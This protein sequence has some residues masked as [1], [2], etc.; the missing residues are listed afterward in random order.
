[1]AFSE[2]IPKLY[3]INLPIPRGGFESFLDGWLIRDEKRRRTLLVETGPASA[4]GELL[5][6][7]D[8]NGVEKIDYLLFTHIHLD[9]SG[10]AGH[11]LKAHPETK[12]TVPAKG[13]QHL[14]D[15][16][17]LIEG[18]RGSLGSLCDL[19]GE[20]LPV[21]EENM[22]RPEEAIPGLTVIDTPGHA[23][24]HSSYI[25][26][27]DGRRLLFAGE[28]AGCW[29]PLDGGDFF[30]RPAAPHKFF[31]DTAIASLEKL[32]A[33]EDIDLVCFPHSGWLKDGKEL[34]LRAKEQMKLWLEI[35][36]SLPASA[37]REAAA[38]ALKAGDPMLKKLALL[39]EAVRKREE[40]FIRQSANGYLGW[41]RRNKTA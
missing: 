29:F 3:R 9:H 23:P 22:L 31:Y 41:L 5:R 32:L 39:P 30:M 2:I 34:F 20:P 16:R 14:I 36:S 25:Y 4:V 17:K 37:D 8:S 21:P 11:F 13:R 26:E 1:M 24:H 15:P 12:A 35:T 28:A 38:A 19:Y 27:L 33:L 6:Q 7:L 18:S 40:F 10:G